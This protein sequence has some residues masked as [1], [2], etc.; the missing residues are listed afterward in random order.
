MASKDTPRSAQ[1]ES[2]RKRQI[3]NFLLTLFI[4]RGVPMLLGGDEFR[5]T[6]RGNNNAYCQD[7]ETSWYD[8]R[9]LQQHQDIFRFARDM[10]AMRRAHPVLARERFYTDAEISWFNPSREPPDWSD[11]HARQLACLIHEGVE[12]FAVPDVQRQPGA[13]RLSDPCGARG[14]AVA[15]CGRHLSGSSAGSSGAGPGPFFDD[16]HP[17]RM[18]PRSSALLI[19]TSERRAEKLLIETHMDTRNATFALDTRSRPDQVSTCRR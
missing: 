8:W 4:S 6:Q 16:S 19:G 17:Y 1:I 2:V 9:Y 12:R 10:M 13:G 14:S 11:P 5:R 7:N 15:Y 3:K 18:A